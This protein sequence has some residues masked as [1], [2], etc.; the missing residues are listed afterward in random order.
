M[1]A[2]VVAHTHPPEPAVFSSDVA[3]E[4]VRRGHDVTVFAPFPNRPGGKIYEGYH[5]RWRSVTRE[6]GCRV[7][8]SWHT[9]S[10]RSTMLS[11]FAENISFGLTSTVQLIVHLLGRPRVNVAFLRTW[12][13]F[14]RNLNSLVLRLWG[15]PVVSCA[16][17][18][19]PESLVERGTLKPDGIVARVMLGLDRLHL[20]Q[21]SAI[22]T[23][24]PGMAELLVATRGL[25][26]SRVNH[27]PVYADA[28]PFAQAV[29]PLA[30][31]SRHDI[32]VSVFL[33]MFVGSLTQSA[34]LNLYI[35][36]ADA[37]RSEDG[38]VILLV[39]DGPSRADLERDISDRKLSNIV[40]V[41][42][43]KPSDVPEV[44]AAADVLL[45]SLAG[46]MSLSATPSK[47]AFY[48]LSGKPIV[49]SV[50]AENHSAT[51]LRES[52]SG[53]V[54]PPGD[55]VAVAQVLRSV[56]HRPQSLRQMGENARRYALR[57]FSRDA[58]IPRLVGI[59]G[60]AARI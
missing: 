59:V 9:L 53:F 47:Q 2:F 6:G 15:V 42:P 3:D 34:G 50:P 37:L 25:Q 46:R 39:G 5:R 55:P 36:V 26:G 16:L 30:F 1:R 7:V 23:L 14:A 22:L 35:E 52:Q 54:L 19:Y 13:L 17:D 57:E 45:L 44:Q 10:G 24:T 60:S 49:A 29:S 51:I 43:L 31:R 11:R 12:S 33:A 56:K 4:F 38:I 18:V 28:G 58:V 21:C 20:R 41:H 40:V 8:R 48:M 32:P 27:L